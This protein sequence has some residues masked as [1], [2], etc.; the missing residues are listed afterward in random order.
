M[1]I[2]CT[3][4]YTQQPRM[5]MRKC[6]Y[7]ELTTRQGKTSYTKLLRGIPF[8]RF[9]A[10]LDPADEGFTINLHLDQKAPVY[11]SGAAHA[12]EYDG[13]V[14]ERE[15]ARIESVVEQFRQ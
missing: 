11:Q 9:H 6:G 13:A 15:A 1:K 7:G 10:Y 14:V 2:Y 8:P 12:G 3:G 5:I 4:N